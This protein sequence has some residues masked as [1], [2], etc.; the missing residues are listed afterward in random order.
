[1]VGKSPIRYP[2]LHERGGNQHPGAGGRSSQHVRADS[3]I[4]LAARGWLINLAWADVPLI[5]S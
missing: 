2:Y 4:P 1:M 3:K 5:T